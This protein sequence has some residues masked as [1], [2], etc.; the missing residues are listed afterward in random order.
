MTIAKIKTKI[1]GKLLSSL[2]C[3]TL[4]N[5]EQVLFISIRIIVH[6]L[7]ALVVHK[8]TALYNFLNFNHPKFKLFR[9][10]TD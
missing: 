5:D 10:D 2:T 4:R 1:I 6:S 8:P 7:V 9:I 3:Y